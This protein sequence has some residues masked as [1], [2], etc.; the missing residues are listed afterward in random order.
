MMAREHAADLLKTFSSNAV[1]CFTDGACQGNPGPAGAG[2]YVKLP[3]N[4]STP[5]EVVKDYRALG[6]GT[7]NIAELTAIKL[8]LGIVERVKEGK[9]DGKWNGV[10]SIEILTDSAYAKGVLTQDWKPKKNIELVNDI[11]NQLDR[12]HRTNEVR[13]HKVAGHADIE[14]NMVADELAG[15]GVQESLSMLSDL[16]ADFPS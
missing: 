14:G 12:V 6:Q 3:E 13:I 15:R 9:S 10:G 16:T 1:I 7:N 2:V 11:K 5:G 8:A 4:H